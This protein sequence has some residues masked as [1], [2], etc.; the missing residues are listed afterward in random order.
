[1]LLFSDMDYGLVDSLMKEFEQ[2]NSL[3]IPDD[4]REKV[5]PLCQPLQ[6]MYMQWEYKKFC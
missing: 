4:L 2:K 5:T 1:M 3:R 6:K